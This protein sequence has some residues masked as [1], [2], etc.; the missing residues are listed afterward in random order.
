RRAAG[1]E[2][3]PGEHLDRQLRHERSR[4]SQLRGVVTQPILEARLLD[5]AVSR[6]ADIEDYVGVEGMDPVRHACVVDAVQWQLAVLRRAGCDAIG[7]ADLGAV[8]VTVTEEDL[9][10]IADILVDLEY[11]VLE[12]V[13][14]NVREIGEVITPRIAT[15]CDR[16]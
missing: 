6:R 9:V 1:V 16:V 3:D 8:V 7:P 13:V 14:G 5:V 15:W 2:V 11:P 4:E 10:F 12:L